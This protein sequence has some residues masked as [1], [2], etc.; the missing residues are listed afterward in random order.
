MKSLA[1]QGAKVYMAARSEEKAKTAIEKLHA[2]GLGTNAGMV[3][4]ELPWASSCADCM[5]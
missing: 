1:Q 5:S 2:E 3:T 4:V